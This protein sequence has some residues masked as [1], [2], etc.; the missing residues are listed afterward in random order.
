M[1]NYDYD[2]ITIGAGSGGVR[3][4]RL[5][6]GYGARVAVCEED[7]VGGT[8]VLRGC[9]P[10]KLLI[11]GAHYADYMED[12]VNYG[13]TIEGASHDWGKLIDNK[14]TELDRLNGIYLRIL[15]DN[16]VDLKE[17]R[18]VLVDDHTVE[19]GG[20]RLTAENILIAVG[21]WPSMPNIPGIEHVISS[22]EALELKELPKRMVIVGGG[23]I[24]VEFAGIFASLGVEVT[25]II[26]ADNILRG[27]DS[28]MRVSLFEEMEK[29]GIKILT[30]TV[31]ESIE[32]QGDVFSL[33]LG[34]EEILET[35]CVMYATGRAANT[36]G[37]GLE[38][39]GV[40]MQDN[41]SIKVDE[42][43]RTSQPHIYAVGDVTDRIQLTPVAIQEGHAL[44]DM[45]FNKD[46][47]T[48]DYSNVPSAV[49]STPPIATVGLTEDEAR[50]EY[51]KVDVYDSNFKPLV[52]TLSGRDERSVMK[53]IVDPKSDK[54]VGCHMMGIDAPEII[55]G[56]AIA[57][58]CGAT[59]AQFD[60]T[61]G[62]HPSSAEEF[63]T[64][65]SKRPDPEE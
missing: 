10:K 65:R 11:Y 35:D 41:G 15:R 7:R 12:A 1:S 21:G 58:K 26:R 51:G 4:S 30:E 63:V 27:F 36:K 28:D 9:I 14:N 34:D 37:L 32:K 17:G 8:C 3:A 38:A 61:T 55:Q 19:V 25:E 20:E 60:A 6:G 16:N 54:V 64:M 40:E 62:I 31:V 13:W 18:G 46:T 52:H 24:A 48:T 49:F 43:N 44:A 2:L 57:L 39:A 42:L 56:V 47:R 45:L 53:L 29:R 50:A 33:R 22:N 5:S 59:K 23:Y